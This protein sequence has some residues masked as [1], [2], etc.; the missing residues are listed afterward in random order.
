MAPA[1]RPSAHDTNASLVDEFIAQAE[2][3]E[4]TRK[5]Y[6]TH[7]TEFC[8]WLE[9]QV[10]ADADVCA[11]TTAEV[12]RFMAYLRSG[13]R[14]AKSDVRKVGRDSPSPSTRKNFHAS[15]ASFYRYL[16]SV[17]LVSRN[18]LIGIDTPK[19]PHKPGLRLTAEEVRELLADRGHPRER[20]QVYLLTFTGARSDEVR[21]LTWQDVDFSNQTLL[22][23]GKGEKYRVIDIH[24]RL[25]PELR[26]WYLY[27][28]DYA[29][30]YPKVREAKQDP[31]T[32]YVLM[33]MGG[34]KVPHS[35][36]IRQLKRRAAK[37][38]LHLNETT[39]RDNCSK[40]SPHTLRRTF[41]SILLNDGHYL[42]AVAD[43]LGHTSLNT[44]RKHYAFSSTERRK[45]T[46]RGFNV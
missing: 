46:I 20:M 45:A 37:A 3:V 16:T 30:R 36:M 2:V 1:N 5:K 38:G 35:T 40:V 7:L 11:V 43:V 31:D 25:M 34:K 4:T 6:R 10:G 33:T 23:R 22:V 8:C 14:W 18:P 9:T 42:D 29:S 13:D 28:D 41:A 39:D 15:L 24:P 12:A 44:T 19:V 32:D 17:A 27:Q 26:R 21:S